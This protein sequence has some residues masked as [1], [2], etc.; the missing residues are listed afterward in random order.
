MY[1]WHLMA[2]LMH[3]NAPDRKAHILGTPIQER[4]RRLANKLT[5]VRIK[6]GHYNIAEIFNGPKF[7]A[8]QFP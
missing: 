1:V 2:C 7:T 5:P 4:V 6:T 3:H 8:Q